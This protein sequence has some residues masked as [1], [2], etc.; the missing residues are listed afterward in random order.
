MH[1]SSL[2]ASRGEIEL[3]SGEGEARQLVCRLSS[4]LRHYV[5]IYDV[6]ENPVL[7]PYLTQR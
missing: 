1:G 7:V 5:Y 2:D 3:K 4:H 6:R